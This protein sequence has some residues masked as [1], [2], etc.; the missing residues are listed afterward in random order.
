MSNNEI[1]SVKRTSLT[2][3]RRQNLQAPLLIIYKAPFSFITKSQEVCAIL[4]T[5]MHR[6]KSCTHDV[7]KVD[8]DVKTRIDSSPL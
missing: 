5:D 2:L 1:T 3:P 4:K 6:I 8:C 7:W